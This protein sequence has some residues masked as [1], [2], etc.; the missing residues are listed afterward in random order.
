MTLR[1]HITL[2]LLLLFTIPSHAV[3]KEDSLA[4]TL[5]ILRNELTVYHNDYG[6][7]QTIMKQT[8][9]RVFRQLMQTMQRSN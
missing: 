2:L 9:Q 8:S 4:N 3:M 7:R 6:A 5:A 1:Q